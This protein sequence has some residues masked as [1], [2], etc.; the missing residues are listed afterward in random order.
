MT[1][2]CHT[3]PQQSETDARKQWIVL[4][5]HF[6]ERIAHPTDLLEKTGRASK[7]DANPE[8]TRR[9]DRRD[10]CLQAEENCEN[11]GGWNEQRPVPAPG[12][13]DPK[14]PRKKILQAADSLHDSRENDARQPRA[15][16]Y[17]REHE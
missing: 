15:E 13:P 10:K 6:R 4:P 3:P 1:G 7:Q 14:H 5:A 2:K 16:K 9:K 12:K 17:D 11:Q 8:S